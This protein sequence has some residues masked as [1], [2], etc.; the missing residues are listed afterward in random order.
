MRAILG[1]VLVVAGMLMGCGGGMVEDGH[2]E[3][4]P[5]TTAQVDPLASSDVAREGAA[6]EGTVEAMRAPLPPPFC[7]PYVGAACSRSGVRIDCMWDWTEM[8]TC[9]CDG[10]S[11]QCS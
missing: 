11:W 1:V 7:D 10:T 9:Y 8:G 3:E 6:S 4:L 5:G 2:Q